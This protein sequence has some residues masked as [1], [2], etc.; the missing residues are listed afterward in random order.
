LSP[1]A[2]PFFAPGKKKPMFAM[3]E[4][5]RAAEAGEEREEEQHRVRRGR[6]LHRDANADRRDEQRG[7]GDRRP[8]PPPNT[9]TA[10]E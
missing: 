2:V 10:N 5:I 1:S 9:W 7:G 4:A 8:Q 6:I 3:L